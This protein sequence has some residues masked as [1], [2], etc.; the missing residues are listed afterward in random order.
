M[1][2][3]RQQPRKNWSCRKKRC[4]IGRDG[5]SFHKCWVA[6]G[7]YRK[8]HEQTVSHVK[9]EVLSITTINEAKA[10]RRNKR[11]RSRDDATHFRAH[12]LALW[13]NFICTLGCII[14]NRK[15]RIHVKTQPRLFTSFGQFNID[16]I[17]FQDRLTYVGSFVGWIIVNLCA[18]YGC[19]W[20][21]WRT[22]GSPKPKINDN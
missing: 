1:W 4:I 14:N 9:A 13:S 15:F 21:D 19:F 3:E 22:K 6:C 11:R 5:S 20:F 2:N 7:I 17:I 18:K 10:W 8:K 12:H 16:I